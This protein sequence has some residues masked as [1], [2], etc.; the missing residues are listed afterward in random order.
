MGTLYL[1]EIPAV[2][3]KI[4]EQIYEGACFQV[5]CGN[6]LSKKI[7]IT[8]GTKT[9]DQLSVIIF[10]LLIDR[11][12]QPASN[13][14]MIAFNIENEKNINPLPT[15]A[16]ADDIALISYDLR[17]LEEMIGICETLFAEVGL[18]VKGSKCALF[19]ERR[20]GNT[21]Y[22]GKNDRIPTQ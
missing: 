5:R 10:L 20:S 3:C 8:K 13:H 1:Y 17:M 22:K 12:F 6:N 2:Y 21:W 18:K 16:Y 4:I 14:A 15:Q 9:G 11:A 7:Y 19:Y